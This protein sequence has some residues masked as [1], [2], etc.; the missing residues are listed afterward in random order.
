[1]PKVPHDSHSSHDFE[2]VPFKMHPRVLAALGAE[3]VTNDIV[4]VIELVK[5]SYDAFATNAWI[6]F[7]RNEEG[8]TFLE[9]ED[10]GL[11]MSEQIL[12]NIWCTI[13][14]P[15]KAINKTAK[16]GGNVR[17]VTG[18]KG[19]G[20]LSAARLG[21]SLQLITR[22]KK[23]PCF[24]L[25]VDWEAL[26]NEDVW[27]HCFARCRPYS[28]IESI[29]KTGT[30]IRVLDLYTDWDEE[31]LQDLEDN[32]ARLISPFSRLDDFNIHLSATE[33]GE[34]REVKIESPKFLSQPKYL[35]QGTVTAEGNIQAEYR[36][37][38]IRDGK[39]RDAPLTLSWEQVLDLPEE[40]RRPRAGTSYEGGPFEFEIRAWDLGPNDTDEISSRFSLQK[41]TIRR[42]I[43]AHKGISLYRDKILVL[44]KSENARDWL[45]LDLRRVSRVGSR[46][47]TS[48]VVG[49]VAISADMNPAIVDT[50]DR[51]RL[52]NSKEVA[53]FEHLLMAIIGLLEGQKEKDRVA[54][55][56]E[57]PIKDLFSNLTAD[58]VVKD[59]QAMAN[60][61]ADAKSVMPLI[62]AFNATLETA[63][64]QLQERFSYY[65]RMA[66][67]GTIAQMLVHE[68]RNRTTSIGH[69]FDTLKQRIGRFQDD[70]LNRF[71]QMADNS[72]NSLER[73]ADTFAP[74]ASR[75]FVRR[76][77]RC[78]ISVCVQ[79]VFDMFEVDIVK[80]KVRMTSSLSSMIVA[81]D[82][83][84][85]ESILVNLFSNSLY[86]LGQK[87]KDER[88]I[89]IRLT[90][91]DNGKRV[92]VWFHDSGPGIDEDNI[93]K[94]LLPGVTNKP[95]GIGM[96]LTVAS[97][98][99]AEYGGRMAVKHQGN[100]GGASFSFDLP[101]VEK[102]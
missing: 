61:G 19:L 99:V 12:K 74:L 46:L 73:L 48:Q 31:R 57:K 8:R 76:K 22:A 9:V 83:G 30:R 39:K 18:E 3:L 14:T 33:E 23:E 10:D 85:V 41:S 7:G 79:N 2:D 6:R 95:D 45:G 35:I 98:I 68:I 38:P 51:E 60:E 54:D 89:Q 20:R 75:S 86:W 5:N 87:K 67:V 17:R 24:E 56:N 42:A 55:T 81:A 71:S 101:L 36:F 96:G 47:S 43:A 66:T 88:E 52:V 82:P 28:G 59:V 27:D 93:D 97:E 29:V 37:R 92:R 70:D 49:Y 77:R 80:K 16:L 40:R 91:I 1:M 102:A 72:L 13:A 94:V 25:V 63:R 26:S 78:D 50:S 100:L 44:P 32:L 58:T 11:G 69:F 90:Q 15:N 4:A 65:S 64:T 21:E 62:H 84:E 53:Q 34:V